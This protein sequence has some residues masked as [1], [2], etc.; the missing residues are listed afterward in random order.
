MALNEMQS[1][2]CLTSGNPGYS[3]VTNCLTMKS[4]DRRRL[5]WRME[6]R[7]GQQKPVRRRTNAFQMIMV[8]QEIT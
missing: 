5:L 1:N 6:V 8:L 2:F 7:D 4:L 3:A